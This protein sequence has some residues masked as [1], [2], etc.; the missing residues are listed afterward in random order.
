MYAEWSNHYLNP[1]HVLGNVV[2]KFAQAYMARDYRQIFLCC[3][4]RTDLDIVFEI[5]QDRKS[6][7]RDV[8]WCKFCKFVSLFEYVLG[9]LSSCYI[10][11]LKL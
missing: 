7:R 4:Q 9:E 11:S 3:P 1:C 2:S 6:L 5:P 10:V 8:V